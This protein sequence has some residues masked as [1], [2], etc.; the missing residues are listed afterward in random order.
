MYISG[1]CTHAI[2]VWVIEPKPDLLITCRGGGR[3]LRLGGHRWWCVY[4]YAHARGVWGMLPP[5]PPPPPTPNFF[6]KLGALR[7]LLR[8]YLY[9]NQDSSYLELVLHFFVTKSFR[10]RWAITA[11]IPAIRGVV[12]KGSKRSRYQ[13]VW[14]GATKGQILTKGGTL[15]QIFYDHD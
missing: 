10:D 5:P 12:Q 1:K 3:Y 2:L 7:S 11:R 9:S 14:R 6:F 4:K 8:P 15:L 13:T